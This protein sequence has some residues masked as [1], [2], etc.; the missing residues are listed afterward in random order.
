MEDTITTTQIAPLLFPIEPSEY[1]VS[2]ISKEIQ[3]MLEGQYKQV[4]IKGELSGVKLHTS[5]HLYYIVKDADSTLD[6]VCWRGSV[7]KLKVKPQDGLE[8]VITGKISTFAARSKYLIVAEQMEEAGVGVLQRKFLELKEKLEKEGLFNEA[9]KKKIPKLPKF[10]GIITSPTGAVIQDLA[11]RLK[12]RYTQKVCIWPTL[13]QGDGS[14]EQIVAAINGFNAM[15]NKPD[16]IIIARG[17]GSIEDLW[18]FNEEAVIRA[19]YNS[20]IPIIS[21]VGHETDTTLCDF[22]ADIRCPTPSAAGEIVASKKTDI[23]VYLQN[24]S[25]MA[26]RIVASKIE[27]LTHKTD[28]LKVHDPIKS[29]QQK[30]L[31]LDD[32]SLRLVRNLELMFHVK[33]QIIFNKTLS[34][35]N[36]ILKVENSKKTLDFYDLRL[37]QFFKQYFDQKEKIISNCGKMLE[38]YS[39]K[40]T[41]ER[42]F[43]LV[44]SESGNVITSSKDV[45]NFQSVCVMFE[46]G[47]VKVAPIK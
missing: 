47:E 14:V 26:L 40:K 35:N 20:N 17:G 33:H 27:N 23:Q 19:V 30:I 6:G 29:Q 37:K 9:H 5:G 28:S 4:R 31:K 10:I 11:H 41:L 46:D 13:V 42:G 21:A 45:L 44:R 3:N 2:Q 22:V 15:E 39:F 12:E 1:S 7:S 16:V 8:V 36:L 43:T 25:A 34:P 24:R 38:A 32:Y 18:S